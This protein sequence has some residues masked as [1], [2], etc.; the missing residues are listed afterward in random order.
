MVVCVEY[1]VGHCLVLELPEVKLAR[2]GVVVIVNPLVDMT[3]ILFVLSRVRL[4][5]IESTEQYSVD[6]K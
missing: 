3:V 4:S 6:M 1:V 2:Y 5:C